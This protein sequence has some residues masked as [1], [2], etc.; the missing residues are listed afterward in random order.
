MANVFCGE[1]TVLK[2]MQTV[3]AFGGMHMQRGHP[4][5]AISSQWPFKMAC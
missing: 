3:D 5:L 4:S 1:L 2:Q